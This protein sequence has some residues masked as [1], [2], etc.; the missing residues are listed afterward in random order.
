MASLYYN[1]CTS[2]RWTPGIWAGAVKKMESPTNPGG[3]REFSF[4]CYWYY[5]SPAVQTSLGTVARLRKGLST[6]PPPV[7]AG[8]GNPC[9]RELQ[10]NTWESKTWLKLTGSKGWN[11]KENPFRWFTGDGE[12]GELQELTALGEYAPGKG[13]ILPACSKSPER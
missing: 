6:P 3:S 4:M 11:C 7:A 5:L 2:N 12:V 13:K 10:G 9:A 8:P 1:L